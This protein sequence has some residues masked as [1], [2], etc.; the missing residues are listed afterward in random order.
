MTLVTDA[1]GTG[2]TAQQE[3][4]A[5]PMIDWLLRAGRLMDDES[6]LIGEFCRRMVAAGVPLARQ[7]VGL[8]V[9]HPKY[10]F[11]SFYWHRDRAAVEVIE[12][13]HGTE[14]STAY[15]DSPVHRIVEGGEDLLRFVI[16]GRQAPWPHPIL[17]ELAEQG[18]TDYVL[19]A[20]RF[21]GGNRHMASFAT[22]RPGGFA[23]ADFGVIELVLPALGAAL[24]G[25]MLRRTA[26]TVLDTY[27]GRRTG[28]HILDGGIRRDGGAELRAVLWYCDLRGFTALADRLPRV[29]LISLLNGYFDIMGGSVEAQGAEILKFIGDAMLAIFPLSD[30]EG[31]PVEEATATQAALAAARAA[32]A[33]IDARNRERAVWGEPTLRCGIALHVGEVM[34]GNIGAEGRLD[35]TVIGPAVNLV[36][37]IEGLC[38]ELDQPVLASAAFADLCPERLWP[39][40]RHPVKGLAD[41]VAV[42]GLPG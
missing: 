10:V 20:L 37:R 30:A 3:Q 21:G 31:A 18:M 34:Y 9:L 25:M 1:P 28:G 17:A 35:F 19:A 42:F 13:E 29:G 38:K 8:G 23:A 27:V 39:L 26:R 16:E 36:N 2:R 5:V 24:E 7:T 4:T 40:G 6:A 15:L 12:R 33:G 41:P 11:R 32:L 14:R 22:D